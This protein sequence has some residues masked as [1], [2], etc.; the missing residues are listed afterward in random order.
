MERLR[1]DHFVERR[2]Y[3]PASGFYEVG[4]TAGGRRGDFVTS[5]EVGPLFGLLIGRWLDRIWAELGRPDPFRVV[6][7]GA[8]RGTLARSVLA[9]RPDCVG[10]LR[11][12]AVERSAALRRHIEIDG[13]GVEPDVTAAGPSD[14]VLANELLDNVPFRMLEH[15]E[16]R[17][18]DVWVET[19]RDGLYRAVL[20]D[21]V[22]DSIVALEAVDGVRLPW[23]EKASDWVTTARE[24]AAHGRVLVIDYGVVRTADLIGRTW[25]RTYAGHERGVDP[26][27]AGAIDITT[28]VPF[29][30]LPAGA[31]IGTQRDFLDALGLSSLVEEGRRVWA[32][33]A[34]IGDLAA[35]TARSRVG[36]ATALTAADG[37]GGFLAAVWRGSGVSA[38]EVCDGGRHPE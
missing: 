30:Q 35:L 4:G 3:D 27:A 28:D 10:A 22:D 1:F 19:G 37:L 38:H 7:A 12:V 21:A 11:Y 2:L 16:G 20:G 15:Q 13:V 24:L 25:C 18:H 5:P 29:D 14:V 26:F 34:S 31:E 33:R 23:C 6:E 17:W 36:E 9:S 32:E 8:G